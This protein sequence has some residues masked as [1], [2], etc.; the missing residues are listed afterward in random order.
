VATTTLNRRMRSVLFKERCCRERN[1]NGI[2]AIIFF[3]I[4]LHEIDGVLSIG[5]GGTS[6]GHRMARWV[7]SG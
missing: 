6:I 7:T 5:R 3:K 1:T 4:D 2:V